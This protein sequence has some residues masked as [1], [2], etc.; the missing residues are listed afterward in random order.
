MPNG[1]TIY[2]E[3]PEPSAPLSSL[4]PA[5]SD[6]TVSVHEPSRKFSDTV[7]AT[8][9]PDAVNTTSTHGYSFPTLL[10]IREM[11]KST[12]TGGA[13]QK[14]VSIAVLLCGLVVAAYR[15]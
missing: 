11:A 5:E 4:I 13:G 9:V 12:K 1:S 7:E 2:T 10:Q 8:A 6:V 14:S 3:L 15:A